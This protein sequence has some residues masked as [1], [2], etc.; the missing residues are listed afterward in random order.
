VGICADYV[1]VADAGSRRAEFVFEVATQFLK[2]MFDD[3]QIVQLEHGAP[4]RA[5]P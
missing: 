3:H 1:G 5:Y 2:Q 4:R